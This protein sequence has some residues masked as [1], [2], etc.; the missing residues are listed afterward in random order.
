[1]RDDESDLHFGHQEKSDG[2]S[3]SGFYN[4]LLPDGRTQIV[5]YT[6]DEIH[7]YVAKVEYFGGV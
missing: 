6:A 1:M 5:T 3:V 7:G 4:V 2:K